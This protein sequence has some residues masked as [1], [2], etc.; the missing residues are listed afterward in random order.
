MTLPES[1]AGCDCSKAR[2]RC[3]PGQKRG[4]GVT[5]PESEAVCDPAESETECAIRTLDL[6]LQGAVNDAPRGGV[7]QQLRRLSG[8]RAPQRRQ[9]QHADVHQEP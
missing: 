6:G 9:D 4:L 2:L 1:E 7:Q 5:L 8:N 3:D